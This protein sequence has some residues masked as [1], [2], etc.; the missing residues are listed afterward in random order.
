MDL[1]NGTYIDHHK[2]TPL[3]DEGNNFLFST[4]HYFDSIMAKNNFAKHHSGMKYI[5]D[6]D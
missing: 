3:L 4:A 2:V 6:G 1:P 5:H